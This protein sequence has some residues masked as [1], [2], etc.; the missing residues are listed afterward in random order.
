MVWKKSGGNYYQRYKKTELKTIKFL[1]IKLLRGPTYFRLMTKK[2]MLAREIQN[3][4][5]KR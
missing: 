1:R 2:D 3:E 4:I 5:K